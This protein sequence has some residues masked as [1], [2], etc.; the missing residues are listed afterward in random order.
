MQSG[1]AACYA[2]HRP[3]AH[4]KLGWSQNSRRALVRSRLDPLIKAL[5]LAS[6]KRLLTL[7]YVELLAVGQHELPEIHE[8]ASVFSSITYNSNS[9]TWLDCISV[10]AKPVQ[11]VR[12][13]GFDGPSFDLAFI[14]CHLKRNLCMGI[15]H[16]EFRYCSL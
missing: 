2:T 4:S 13:A 9:V 6:S 11:R 1:T 12:T 16:L 14:V 8:H 15:D 5:A 10:P 7:Y 3:A